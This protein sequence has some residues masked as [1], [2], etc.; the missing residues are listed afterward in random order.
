M[1]TTRYKVTLQYDGTH[2]AGFQIQPKCRTV[3]GE[4]E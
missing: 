4:I 1:K 3:Q 2:F